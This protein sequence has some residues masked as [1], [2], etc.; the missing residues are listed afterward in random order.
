MHIDCILFV[1]DQ[2]EKVAEQK[3]NQKF[4][5]LLTYIPIIYSYNSYLKSY[6]LH[7]TVEEVL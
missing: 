7:E 6:H 4:I 5:F 2:G 3:L 1:F